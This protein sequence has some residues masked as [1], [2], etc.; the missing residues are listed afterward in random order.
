MQKIIILFGF[1][2]VFL[3]LN[4][5]INPEAFSPENY[6]AVDKSSVVDFHN[7]RCFDLADSVFTVARF[8]FLYRNSDIRKIFA[9]EAWQNFSVFF[10]ED[11]LSPLY[12]IRK[13]KCRG[14]SVSF[15]ANHRG[16]YWIRFWNTAKP[17][18]IEIDATDLPN[19]R[20]QNYLGCTLHEEGY[21][22]KKIIDAHL[23]YFHN[24]PVTLTMYYRIRSDNPWQR[25]KTVPVTGLFAVRDMHFGEHCFLFSDGNKCSYYNFRISASESAESSG[26]LSD[27][28][29]P[30]SLPPL[31]A[32]RRGED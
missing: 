32:D 28:E 23:P 30:D 11:R 29:C 9:L 31:T 7:A 27:C 12:E 15:T 19:I 18:L 21:A 4:A 17:T 25:I 13:G 26:I 1:L 2:P 5:Q 14:F 22:E 20:V 24:E 10:A 16:V 6:V 8:P 3:P